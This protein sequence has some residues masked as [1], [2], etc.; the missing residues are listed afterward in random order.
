MKVI[1]YIRSITDYNTEINI[2]KI[3]YADEYAW[4]HQEVLLCDRLKNITI[5]FLL[6]YLDCEVI[7]VT[8]YYNIYDDVEK[9]FLTIE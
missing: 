7:Q 6:E 9:V 1:E 5:E 2:C 8:S 4:L 3:E